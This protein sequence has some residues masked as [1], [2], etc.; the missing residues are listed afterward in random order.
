MVQVIVLRRLF[1][2]PITSFPSYVP[3]ST[4]STPLVLVWMNSTLGCMTLAL[5]LQIPSS[6][7]RSGTFLPSLL[8][9]H[10]VWH[11]LS[12][13][14]HLSLQFPP[15]PT[16]SRPNRPSAQPPL[17]VAW[18]NP[19][20]TT[21]P[22]PSRS[23]ADIIHGGTSEFDQA[24]AANAAA[25]RGKGK[26]RGSP[27]AS[28]ASKVAK[29]ATVVEA[30]SPKGPSPLTSAARRFYAPRNSPAPNPEGNLI[31]IRWPDMAASVLRE[32]NS[33]LPVSLKVFINGNGAVSL[34]LINTSV[35]ATSYTPFFDTLTHKLNQSFPVGNNPRLPFRLAPND[36][37]VCHS[38][39]PLLW[40]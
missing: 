32:P 40:G 6:A 7:Q 28:T 24:V 19:Q 27:L 16:S 13:V 25:W 26:G 29:V 2:M 17:V 39:P 4:L 14:P 30:A 10:V 22:P 21:A 11:P 8:T 20:Q 36:L 33:G 23:Y 9:C 31:R 1:G 35:L 5:R 38:W 3:L 15:H 37:Q 18:D 12:F 34:T